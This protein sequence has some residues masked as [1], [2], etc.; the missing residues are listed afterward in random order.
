MKYTV[1]VRFDYCSGIF[2]T[3]EE[4]TTHANKLTMKYFGMT[5]EDVAD[6]TSDDWYETRENANII[7]IPLEVE[8]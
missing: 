3:K 6:Y 2:D 1:W 5:E 4:A 7:P 8:V